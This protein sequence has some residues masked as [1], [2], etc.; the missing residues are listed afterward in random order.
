MNPIPND[1]V[2]GPVVQCMHF[3]M[4]FDDYEFVKLIKICKKKYRKNYL[5]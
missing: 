3:L 1:Y 4:L 2:H 5:I